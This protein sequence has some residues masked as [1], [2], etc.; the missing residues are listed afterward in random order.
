MKRW[1]TIIY[2]LII[3]VGIQLL[4]SSTGMAL[5]AKVERYKKWFIPIIIGVSL[6]FIGLGIY[7]APRPFSEEIIGL[8]ILG[9]TAV[10]SMI[11]VGFQP[12]PTL[13]TLSRAKL[14]LLLAVLKICQG[15]I[16]V[17]RF[18]TD[19][20]NKKVVLKGLML[21]TILCA[22]IWFR[23]PV[24]KAATTIQNQ[25]S[26][27]AYLNQFG[28]LAPV[29]LS[30][31]LVSQVFV[32]AIP[33]HFLILGG[34]YVYGFWA[35]LTM[36]MIATVGASQLA[37]LLAK[38]AGRPVVERLAPAPVIDKWN[39]AAA[40]NGM[41]FF[42]FAFM[43]PVFPADVMNYVAGL[44]A[45]TG[46]RFFIANFFGRLPGLILLSLVGAYGL[47]LTPLLLLTL[48]AVG[49]LMF[50]GWYYLFI[51]NKRSRVP[52]SGI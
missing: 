6:L 31:A 14:L 33:G 19:A 20:A 25:D 7:V 43:L 8:Q 35:I 40:E 2:S 52:T 12:S 22:A 28:P 30:I 24:L 10:C 47:T 15:G 21:I 39:A 42:M 34:G 32:A 46:R 51:Y 5:M 13:N 16:I 41:V 11:V 29:L 27:V 48:T 3:V 49:L 9:V 37:F 44:S 26:V 45:I 17:I 36:S 4:G 38:W 18:L 50:V 1:G 23:Q